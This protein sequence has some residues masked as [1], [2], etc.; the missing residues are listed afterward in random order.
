MLAK[1]YSGALYGM[2]AFRMSV[3][4]SVTS[5]IGYMITG[6]PDDTIKES[7]P[8]IAI[9]IVSYYI[10]RTKL[11]INLSPARVKKTG[12]AFDLPFALGILMASEQVADLGKL[13]DYWI[14]GEIGLHGNIYPIRGA[15]CMAYQAKND[16]FKGMVVPCANANENLPRSHLQGC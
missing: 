10:P 14:A 4:V 15:L 9:A 1:I 5:G 7:L 8:R 11:V 2:E 13:K 12:T 6:L 16:G 3:E